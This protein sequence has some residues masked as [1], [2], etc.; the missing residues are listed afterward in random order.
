MSGIQ[1]ENNPQI[2][3]SLTF[4]VKNLFETTTEHDIVSKIRV[5]KD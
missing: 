5:F 4:L 2:E 1:A 3:T